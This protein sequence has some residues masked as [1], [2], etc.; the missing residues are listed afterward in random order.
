MKNHIFACVLIALTSAS[1]MAQLNAPTDVGDL[2][3]A[4]AMA[5]QENYQG[6][7]DQLRLIDGATTA[8]TRADI[9]Y[10]RAL[11]LLKLGRYADSADAFRNFLRD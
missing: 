4:D 11:W 5:A 7:L 3:R 9:A 8:T 6:A 10:R 2:A 1:A